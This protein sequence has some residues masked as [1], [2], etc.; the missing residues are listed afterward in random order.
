MRRIP[1]LLLIVVLTVSGCRP[2]PGPGVRFG[3]YLTEPGTDS[4]AV[5]WRTGTLAGTRVE[6][7]GC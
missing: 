2:T 5:H 7:G 3:P 1:G 4:I 6:G